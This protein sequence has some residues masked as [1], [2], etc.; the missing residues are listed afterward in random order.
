MSEELKLFLATIYGEAALSSS[1]AW[2]A[3]AS[4]I[5]NRV[6]SRE[7]RDMDTV[8]AVIRESGFDAYK[9]TNGPFLRA[10]RCFETGDLAKNSKLVKLLDTVLP[11]YERKLA[12]I[13]HIVM[14]YSPKAQALLHHSKPTRYRETPPWNFNLLQ[15][16]PVFGAEGDDFKFFRY[17]PKPE[18]HSTVAEDEV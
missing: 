5:L 14:Y 10:M 2:H 15:E 17:K 3:I 4:V 12:P 11:L 16:V 9:E 6:N 13:P 1:C 7:W 18:V 8:E